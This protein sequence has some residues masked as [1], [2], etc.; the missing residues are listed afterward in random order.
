MV[1]YQKVMY[2]PV[3]WDV[4][5]LS[6]GTVRAESPD[7]LVSTPDALMKWD[8]NYD[9]FASQVV[10]DKKGSGAKARFHLALQDVTLV[11]RAVT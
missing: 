1:K 8:I 6:P 4:V 9:A 5:R 3:E 2:P 11:P 10:P 7:L